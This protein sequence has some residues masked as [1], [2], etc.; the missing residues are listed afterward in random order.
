MTKSL[1]KKLIC[2]FACLSLVLPLCACGKGDDISTDGA[3]TPVGG[4]SEVVPNAP[5]YEAQ[6]VGDKYFTLN[7]DPGYSFNPITGTNTLNMLV[8]GLMYEPLFAVGDDFEARRVLC[9]DYTTEDGVTFD[10]KL[11]QG[12]TF[13]DGTEMTSSD[14]T[15]TYYF[16]R[17]LS[18]Y[19]ARLKNIESVT[20]PDDY[21]VSVTLK[22]AN[23]GLPLLLDIPIIKTGTIDDTVPDGTGAYV[24]GYISDTSAALNAYRGYRDHAKLPIDSIRLERTDLR[25]VNKAFT[26]AALDLLDYDPNGET[27]FSIQSDHELN[28]YNTTVFDYVGFNSNKLI[29]TDMRRAFA[30]A[31]DREAIAKSIYGGHALAAAEIFSPACPYYDHRL[32][33]E[34]EYSLQSLSIGLRAIGLDDHDGDS[35]LEY[36]VEGGMAK[37]SIR[38]IV[39]EEDP[40]RVKAAELISHALGSIGIN[41]KLDKL[42]WE[43][44]IEALE[45]GDFDMYYAEVKL[46]SDFDFTE[47]LTKDGTLNYGGITHEA[48]GELI[49]AFSSS[50]E[51]ERQNAASALAR[52]VMQNAHIIPVLYKQNVVA[53]HRNVITGIDANQSDLF[54]NISDWQIDI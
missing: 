28:F 25:D 12:V 32:A 19:S 20:A 22:S 50:P 52:E 7:F 31:V 5:V 17:T 30:H 39:N 38:F 41:V 54:Y 36:P 8:A 43:E 40:A 34:N 37:L 35:Y 45:K 48:Y 18:K 13:H 47:L 44:Y 15:Y 1:L 10:F 16:A 49:A 53:S 9:E 51:A 21:T 6:P 3:D 33:E 42:P 11:R 46:G 23:Y 4:N 24:Y 14:V 2:L 27:S 29:N 26:V